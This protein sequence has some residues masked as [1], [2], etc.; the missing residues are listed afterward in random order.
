MRWSAILSEALHDLS[1]GAAR[2][3]LFACLLCL[4]CLGLGLADLTSI[5]SIYQAGQRFQ[6]SGGSTLVYSASGAID[7]KACDSLRSVHGVRAAGAIRAGTPQT[8]ALLPS[9]AIPTFE[10]SPGFGE[11]TALG[12]PPAN[13]GPVISQTVAT[14]LGLKVGNTTRLVSGEERVAG[15]YQYRDDGR[16]PGYGYAIMLPTTNATAFDQC[17]VEIWPQSAELENLLS[18]TLSPGSAAQLSKNPP[19]LS[20]LNSTL[21]SAFDGEQLFNDRIT[22]FAPAGAALIGFGLGFAAIRSRRLEL[23]SARH[24]GVQFQS[25]AAQLAFESAAWSILGAADVAGEGEV[26]R[27]VDAVHRGLRRGATGATVVIQQHDGLL[28]DHLLR[29]PNA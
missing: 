26:E 22:R 12:D 10:V 17:W 18:S 27:G 29:L 5:D 13:Q 28:D 11:F 23:A 6:T 19:Q 9:G 14:T 7:G 25:Q 21:G 3:V 15:I 8:S 4:A 20:Q 1:T 2:G 16:I 24:A